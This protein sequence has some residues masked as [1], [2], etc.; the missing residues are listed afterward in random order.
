[1]SD[2]LNG[3]SLG[4]EDFLEEAALRD[5][6]KAKQDTTGPRRAKVSSCKAL[7]THDHLKDMKE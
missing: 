7:G 3:L 2:P 6:A 4:Q 5:L 1:M